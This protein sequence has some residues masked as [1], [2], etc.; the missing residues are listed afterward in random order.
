[1][2]EQ[3]IYLFIYFKGE[4]TW[5]F[6]EIKKALCYEEPCAF[7]PIIWGLTHFYC[8]NYSRL[9]VSLKYSWET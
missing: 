7:V 5:Y 2:N 3:T 6:M 9:K 4:R 1:M 8:P